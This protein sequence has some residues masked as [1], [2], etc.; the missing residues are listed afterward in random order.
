[1]SAYT[2]YD[3]LGLA[4][5]VR[6]GD[7]TV[8]ELG[9]AMLAAVERVNPQINAVIETYAQRVEA[10]SQDH[11]PEGV[12]GGVPFLLKDLFMYESGKR[13]ESGSRLMKGWVSKDETLLTTRFKHAGL[14]ILGRTTTPEFG[15]SG[16]TESLH[17]GSTRN[18]WDLSKMA[19]G[20]SGGSAAA[21]ASGIVP[22]AHASDGAGSI[23][24]P[25]S[26][27][28]LVGLKTSRGRISSYPDAEHAYNFAVNFIVSRTVRDTA[29]MLDAVAGSA[30]GDLAPIAP[31]TQ[32]YVNE[33]TATPTLL[34]IAVTTDTWG[35]VGTDPEVAAV[36]E[37][38]ATVC[39]AA[40]PQVTNASPQ[41]EYEPFLEAMLVMWAFGVDS[42]FEAIAAEMGRSVDASTLERVT[43]SYYEYA[44]TLTPTDF[45][46][47]SGVL[48]QVNRNTGH[49]FENYDVL[50]TPTLGLLP[51]DIGR[52]SQNQHMNFNEFF[53]HCDESM[54][55]LPLF[56]MTGQPA[57]SLPLGM[58]KSG[59]PIGVQFAA[60]FG[61]EATL[62]QLAVQLE[63]AMPWV[64]RL[65]P[66]YA[67]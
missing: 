22:M 9:A 33:L 38:V 32:P 24:I 34:R 45:V 13:S 20:S 42:F 47:A 50:L 54:A 49:F 41:Y 35:P 58:S 4:E 21:V 27:C 25:A 62:I 1:L 37:Q 2:H 29:A 44:Q 43:L 19:G 18:P 5:L 63:E 36:V 11:K 8:K 55:F 28:N 66:V 7:V 60:R 30:P 46:K 14:N 3:G 65:P 15:L 64:G 16:S 56:N 57:I 61:D 59:L 52:Y 48:N 17:T 31:P 10:L 53:R 40:G 23:R 39:E 26:C 67:T 12:F 51:Q 6:N